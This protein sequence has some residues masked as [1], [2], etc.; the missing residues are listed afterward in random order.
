ML[1]PRIE[2]RMPLTA[3][4]MRAFSRRLFVSTLACL[5]NNNSNAHTHTHT[6]SYAKIAHVTSILPHSRAV[7]FSPP[8]PPPP[9][10]P[11]SLLSSPNAN[12]EE[13]ME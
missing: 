13:K 12:Q 11:S 9:P 8:P 5:K 10:L 1:R 3:P 7:E 6:Q 4:R 2:G